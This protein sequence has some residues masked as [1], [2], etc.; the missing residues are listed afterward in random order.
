MQNH[1]N[2]QATD[3]GQALTVDPVITWLEQIRDFIGSTPAAKDMAQR[4]IDQLRRCA[5]QRSA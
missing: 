5:H 3:P 1:T 4:A 2:E